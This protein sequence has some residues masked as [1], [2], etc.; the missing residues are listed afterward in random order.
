MHFHHM[1][2]VTT[3]IDEQIHFWRDIMDFELKVKMTIPDGEEYGPTT[4]APRSLMRD[5]L[6]DHDARAT[7]ALMISNGGAMIELLQPELPKVEATPMEKR[8]Y[9][10]S[11]I[12]EIAIVVDG[13]DA[14]FDK[15]RAAGYRTQTDYIWSCA[16]MGRSF[17]FYDKEGNMIQMWENAPA[18]LT[19]VAEVT[20]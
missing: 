1:C 18:P 12:R 7:V 6:K 8:L 10:D 5:T 2:I 3:E 15:V 13:I 17:I 20:V 19:P 9:R 4:F 16:T 14:F 11:G